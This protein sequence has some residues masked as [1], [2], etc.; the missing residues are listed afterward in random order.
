MFLTETRTLLVV[1]SL[2]CLE[3]N[4]IVTLCCYGT[5]LFG[6][7]NECYRHGLHKVLENVKIVGCP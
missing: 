6:I 1:L 5:F 2:A 3:I 7:Q 4:F